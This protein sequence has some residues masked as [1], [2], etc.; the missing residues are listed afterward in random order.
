M[1]KKK[2]AKKKAGKKKPQPKAKPAPK[3]K[4]SGLD[5]VTKVLAEAK[6]SLTTKEMVEKALAKGYWKTSGKTP[7]ATIYAGILR[8]MGSKGNAA[9]FRKTGP[10][11]FA[12]R[13]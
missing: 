1:S 6:G 4:M 10:G 7:A 12:L 3:K 2:A 13:K 9:R 11:K 5:A 8:E